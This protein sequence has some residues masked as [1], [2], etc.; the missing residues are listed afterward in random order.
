MLNERIDRQ[1]M[2]ELNFWV[3]GRRK[4]KRVADEWVNL[5]DL[6][7]CFHDS[8]EDILVELAFDIGFAK[9]SF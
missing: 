4:L 5:G 7:I 2:K 3:V 1:K 6:F 9:M 8:V